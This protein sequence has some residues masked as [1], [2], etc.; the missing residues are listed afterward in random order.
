MRVELS[1]QAVSDLRIIAAESRRMFGDSVAIALE[2]RMRAAFDQISRFP[3]AA[4][5]L[6]QR[7]DVRVLSLVRYPYRIFYRVHSDALTILRIL[8]AARTH[9]N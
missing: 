6:E 7:K 2:M 9:N 3:D 4:P 1:P 8:H 5:R